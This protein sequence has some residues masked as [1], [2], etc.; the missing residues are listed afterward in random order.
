VNTLFASPVCWPG[1]GNAVL[2]LYTFETLYPCSTPFSRRK[3][4]LS[5]SPM[6]RHG[7]GKRRNLPSL[8]PGA[9]KKGRVPK[10]VLSCTSCESPEGRKKKRGGGR[11]LHFSAR[12]CPG[13]GKGENEPFM[14]K[15][16]IRFADYP[17][18]KKKGEKKEGGE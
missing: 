16:Q 9:V 18:E 10:R 12:V 17:R 14:W 15:T 13:G 2:D 6:S 4:G 3:E 8:S 11:A 5:T 1:G 7:E